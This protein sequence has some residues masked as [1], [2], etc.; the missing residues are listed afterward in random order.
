MTELLL[1]AY[2]VAHEYQHGGA[3]ALARMLNKDQSTLARELRG[4]PGS[5]LGLETAVHL[6][7]LTKDPRILSAFASM[8]GYM[9]VPLPS[10]ASTAAGAESMEHLARM[11]TEFGDV[12]RVFSQSMADGVVSDNELADMRHEV[13]QLMVAAQDAMGHAQSVH[14]AGVARRGGVAGAGHR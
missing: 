8:A 1:A 9:L 6:T 4:D 5:K 10:A 14:D 11:A 13:G 3:A 2:F 12:A 7:V